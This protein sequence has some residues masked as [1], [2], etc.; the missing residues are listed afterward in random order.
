MKIAIDIREAAGEKAG[1]G[2]YTFHLVHS[3]LTQ[4]K[5]NSYLLYTKE[6]IPGFDQFKN[7][8]EKILQGPSL[9]WHLQ[10][11]RDIKKEKADV[12]FAPTSYIIPAILS[13]EIKSIMVVHD[14]VAFLFA[15][16]HNK[17]AVLLEKL[18]LKKALNKCSH[19]VTVSGNTKKDLTEKF[20]YSDK[21]ISVIYPAA[22]DEF[23]PVSRDSLKNFIKK[24]HL[25][26]K[27][28]LAVSTI[29]P[30]KNYLNLLKAFLKFQ[31]I[32]PE[33]HLIIVGKNGHKSEE[34]A[35]F[36]YDNYLGKKVHLLGYLSN[37]SIVNLYSL[38]ECLIF[39]SFYEGF[40]MP[41]VE[42]MQ[43]GCPVISSNTSS[44][45]EVVG[46]SAILINPHHEKEIFSA[47]KE[48]IENKKL[49]EEL[50]KKGLKESRKFSWELS[51]KRLHGIIKAANH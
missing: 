45:P 1:K 13:P 33:Y 30:R 17:K 36:I 22:S 32:H 42:A 15:K 27:F 34:V 23:K 38:A 41:L 39:P 50:I 48:I 31:K 2:W 37:K 16:D 10:V 20:N 3:L 8:K 49:K 29:I 11:A 9:S 44:M 24:T 35:Q 40:G 5:K 28:F 4:D 21:K 26:N 43:C 12:F 46:N 7:A 6:K 18:F 47:M 51:A 25:P 19:V 14:L